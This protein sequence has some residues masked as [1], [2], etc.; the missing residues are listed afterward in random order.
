M[1]SEENY[2]AP[3]PTAIELGSS[4]PLDLELA[5]SLVGL[6][7]GDRW[8]VRLSGL[9]VGRPVHPDV[10]RHRRSP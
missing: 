4:S 7:P 5:R 3:Y 6:A 8:A 10:V 2:F 9:G 1:P